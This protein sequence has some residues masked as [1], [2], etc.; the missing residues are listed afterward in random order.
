M[1]VASDEDYVLNLVAIFEEL[2]SRDCLTKRFRAG[3]REAAPATLPCASNPSP[4]GSAPRHRPPRA[5]APVA[6]P[7]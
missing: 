4:A 2:L 1:Q 5:R 6:A 3:W 7:V